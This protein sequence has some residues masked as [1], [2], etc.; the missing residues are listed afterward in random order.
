MVIMLKFY[1][2]VQIDSYLH[3][4]S[5]NWSSENPKRLRIIRKLSF[6][7]QCIKMC[8]SWVVQQGIIKTRPGPLEE[9]SYRQQY[10]R[11]THGGWA[12]AS[13]SGIAM[14]WRDSYKSHLSSMTSAFINP[15]S[16]NHLVFQPCNDH[17]LDIG[18][19][20]FEQT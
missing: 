8:C 15:V 12:T 10:D 9:S 11:H 17:L 7:G 2:R 3:V 13:M 19:S 14:K 4:A 5:Y 16:S 18:M 1:P 20:S 6:I